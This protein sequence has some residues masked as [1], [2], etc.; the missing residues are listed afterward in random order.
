MTVEELKAHPIYEFASVV[1]RTAGWKDELKVETDDEYAYIDFGM[2]C[3][4]PLE[5][6]KFRVDAITYSGGDYHEPPFQD[7]CFGEEVSD[8]NWVDGVT[9][10]VIGMVSDALSDC[11]VDRN[12]DGSFYDYDPFNDPAPAALGEA[13]KE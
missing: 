3:F 6:P 2:A 7:I 4:V 5:Y 1:A 12:G 11:R 13:K 10:L 9:E 8:S